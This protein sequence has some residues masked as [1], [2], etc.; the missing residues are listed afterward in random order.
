MDKYEKEIVN[1]AIAFWKRHRPCAW[2]HKTHLDN[3]RVNASNDDEIRLCRAVASRFKAKKKT[4][5]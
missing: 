3:P 5:A 2:D 1:A 4:N